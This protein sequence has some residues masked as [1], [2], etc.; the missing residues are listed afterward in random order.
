MEV[1]SAAFV[2]QPL[3]HPT[4]SPGKAAVSHLRIFPILSHAVRTNATSSALT[5][6]KGLGVNPKIPYKT[7]FQSQFSPAILGWGW[8][9]DGRNQEKAKQN[10]TTKWREGEM[11]GNKKNQ[12]KTTQ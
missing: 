9:G 3:Q 5:W 11:E 7:L 2:P 6:C 12:N 4:G 10:N 8:G 1:T